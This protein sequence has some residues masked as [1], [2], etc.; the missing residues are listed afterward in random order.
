VASQV[1]WP[2]SLTVDGASVVVYQPQAVEWPDHQT[3]TT[4]EAVAITPAGEKSRLANLAVWN[5]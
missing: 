3:L 5:P 2:H 1:A 4:R